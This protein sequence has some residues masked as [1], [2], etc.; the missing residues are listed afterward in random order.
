MKHPHLITSKDGCQIKEMMISFA[1]RMLVLRLSPCPGLK[2][3]TTLQAPHLTLPIQGQLFSRGRLCPLLSIVNHNR[4]EPSAFLSCHRSGL[5]IYYII[6]S[7]R[8][9][10]RPGTTSCEDLWPRRRT[11]GGITHRG[12]RHQ[13]SPAQSF[14]MA[15][16]DNRTGHFASA[17]R[18]KDRPTEVSYCL[19]RYPHDS[20]RASPVVPL[21]LTRLGLER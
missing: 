18:I 2:W 6:V 19:L 9:T 14:Q 8:G 10:A 4:A 13:G 5:G 21:C 17:E 12:K 15:S 11:R 7:C 3:G 16:P 1:I 20:E